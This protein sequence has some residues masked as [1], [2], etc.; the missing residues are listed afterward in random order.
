[1]MKLKISLFK[2][3]VLIAAILFSAMWHIFWLSSVSVVVVPKAAKQIKF[4]GVSFLGPIL[5]RGVLKV[6]VEPHEHT[7]LEKRYLEDMEGISARMVT[8]SSD[9]NYTEPA[10]NNWVY[11]VNDEDWAKITV[12]SIDEQKIEPGRNID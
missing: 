8:A 9:Y 3:K 7:I 1:M 5:D 6:S 2:D 10:L 4:S 11:S 12:A